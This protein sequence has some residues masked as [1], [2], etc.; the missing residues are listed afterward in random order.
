MSRNANW[1]WLLVQN[2]YKCKLKLITSGKWVQV[3][4]KT[5]KI[6]LCYH[7]IELKLITSVNWNWKQGMKLMSLPQMFN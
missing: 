4:T 3:Q 1:I 5:Q 7:F 6:Y 2:E